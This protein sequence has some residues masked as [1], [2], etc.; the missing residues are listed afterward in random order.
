MDS[1]GELR[2]PDRLL[3]GPG[4]SE[5]HPRVLGAFG[6]PPIGHLDPAFLDVMDDTQQLLRGVFRT[7]NTWTIPVSGTGSAAMEAA[8]ANVVEPDDVM[9]APSNGY[10]GDRMAEMARRAGGTVERVEAPWGEPLDPDAVAAACADY[11]PDVIGVVHA[12]TSTGVQRARSPTPSTTTARCSSPT[13]SPPS[14]ASSSGLTSGVSTSPTAAPRSAS[15]VRRAPARSRSERM[16]SRRSANGRR[17]SGRG[18]STSRNWTTTGGRT[19]PTPVNNVYALREA[20]RLVRAEGIEARWAR[21]E[22]YA[23]A[24]RD[25]LWALELEPVVEAD[26]RL[27]SLTTARLP[28]GLDP[29]PVVGRMR[30][31]HEVEIATGLGA[32]AEE[33]VRVGCMGHGARR[34][35]VLET[36]GALGETLVDR[37]VDVAPGDGVAAAVASLN[38]A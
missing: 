38:G 22:R 20:L 28:A 31:A 26:A 24:L 1:V 19:A 34:G 12:E 8:I 27:P 9:L 6:T 17:Q 16:P 32:F 18:T 2:P 15:P 23:T 25:G 5:T 11:D 30:E 3:M 10:F 36:L 4:P 29:G 21:H 35:P 14:A 37:G 33:A 7:D 13:V